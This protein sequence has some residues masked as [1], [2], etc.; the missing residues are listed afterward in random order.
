[1]KTARCWR[2]FNAK[3]NASVRRR[4]RREC[5]SQRKAASSSSAQAPADAS[6]F[7]SPLKMPLTFGTDDADSCSRSAGGKNAFLKAK[8]GVE[9]Q[10][11]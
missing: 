3:R 9:G 1:M 5:P 8:E 7:R 6:V 10:T 4:H 2:P 11:T